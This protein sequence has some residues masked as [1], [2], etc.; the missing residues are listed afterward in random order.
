MATLDEVLS[1]IFNRPA[2]D[3]TPV[4][5]SPAAINA[6]SHPF[7]V[8]TSLDLGGNSFQGG[9][10]TGNNA[11]LARRLHGQLL[12]AQSPAQSQTLL[13][14]LLRIAPYNTFRGVQADFVQRRPE[15]S[16]SGI[17]AQQQLQGVGDFQGQGILQNLNRQRSATLS[18][19]PTLGGGGLLQALANSHNPTTLKAKK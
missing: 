7:D 18:N 10:F 14:E 1:Q 16:H 8:P 4:T 6:G 17:R 5:G 12:N 13:G 11:F 2:A 15:L 9:S 3:N 19:V